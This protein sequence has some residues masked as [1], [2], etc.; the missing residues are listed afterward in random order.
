[1]TLYV[2]NLE[3]SKKQNKTV[4]LIYE[5]SKTGYKVNTQKVAAYHMHPDVYNSTVH[6]SQNMGRD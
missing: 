4:K 3:D 1:M 5:F 6:N 2:P